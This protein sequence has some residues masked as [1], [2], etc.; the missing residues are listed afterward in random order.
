MQRLRR[1]KRGL[2]VEASL[3][4]FRQEARQFVRHEFCSDCRRGYGC[5]HFCRRAQVMT[6]VYLGALVKQKA[7][8]N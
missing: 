3:E 8:W 4:K 6:K 7:R 2:I 5:A 1:D